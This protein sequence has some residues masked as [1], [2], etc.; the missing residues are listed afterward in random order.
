MSSIELSTGV[1]LP[2]VEQGSRSGT[3]VTLLHGA[4]DSWRSFEPVMPFLSPSVRA[5]ALTQRGHGDADKPLTCYRPEDFAGDVVAFLDAQGIERAIIAGHSLG[6]FVAQRVA[7]DHPERV[8]GLV[9]AGS[10]TTLR[11]HAGIGDFW[12][13]VIST[14]TDPID[15]AIAREFQESTVAKPL[16]PG[17]LD[18]FVQESLKAP[19]RVWREIFA[20]MIEANHRPRLGVISAPTLIL[21]GDRD[22]LIPSDEQDRLLA[23]IPNARLTVYPGIGHALHWE[24]PQRFAADLTA[25]VEQVAVHSS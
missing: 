9:L 22:T 19:A 17:L 1:R 13:A 11:D 25:F 3:P 18:T 24:D 2:F 23:G 12:D 8:L 6:S 5:F 16:P 20:G 21:W 10:H 15:P 14:L 7:L 4:T